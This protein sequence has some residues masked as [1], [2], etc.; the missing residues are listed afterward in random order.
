MV[1]VIAAIWAQKESCVWATRISK[2]EEKD[3]LEGRFEDMSA[4]NFL[5]RF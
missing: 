2:K 1:R 3:Q 5:G 4:K